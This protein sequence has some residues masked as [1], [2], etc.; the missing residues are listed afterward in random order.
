MTPTTIVC[1]MI[2]CVDG[3]GRTRTRLGSHQSNSVAA[4]TSTVEIST[5]PSASTVSVHAMSDPR[6]ALVRQ[7]NRAVLSPPAELGDP[8]SVRSEVAPESS[9]SCCQLRV[10]SHLHLRYRDCEPTLD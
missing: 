3:D 4:P 5:L 9:C 6:S 10:I 1:T 2:R 7:A 8:T